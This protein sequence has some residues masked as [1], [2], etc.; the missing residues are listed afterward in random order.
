MDKSFRKYGIALERLTVEPLR[1]CIFALLPVERDQVVLGIRV[2]RVDGDGR[3]KF[4]FCLFGM[5]ALP[6]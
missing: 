3:L 1:L 2:V 4:L 6:C 5:L